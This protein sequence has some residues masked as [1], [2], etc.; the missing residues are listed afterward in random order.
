[1]VPGHQLLLRL[2]VWWASDHREVLRH[3]PAR[4]E[5]GTRSH[6]WCSVRAKPQQQS[7]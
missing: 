5:T 7:R 6:F 3:L 1:M 2:E 4:K